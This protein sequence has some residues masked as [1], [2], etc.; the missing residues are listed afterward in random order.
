MKITAQDLADFAAYERVRA[1]GRFNM[2]DPR[3]WWDTGLDAERFAF[4]Q[5]HYRTLCKENENRNQRSQRLGRKG[6][7]RPRLNRGRQRTLA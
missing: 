3:A 1:E 6:T 7:V 4:V 5:D 2:L